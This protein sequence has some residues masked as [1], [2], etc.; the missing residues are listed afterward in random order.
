MATS[1]ASHT[2]TPEVALEGRSDDLA[3]LLV[4][5]SVEET[6]AG[7]SR[8][9]VRVDN[10]TNHSDGPGFLW[11]DR[12]LVDFGKALDVTMGPPDERALVFS[13]RI[14]GI[15]ADYDVTGPTLVL[16]AEDGLKDLRLTRRTRV[17]EDSTDQ[18]AIEAIAGDH[19]LTPEVE[20]DGASHAA[21][22]QLNQS[23]LA[24][25][26]DRA[27]PYG[28]DVWL[29][30]RTLHVGQRRDEAIVLRYGR[31]LLSV[32]LLADL[33]GQASEQRVTGW[34]P[35]TKQAVSESAGQSSLGAELGRD[36]G[37]GD[38]VA[39]AFGGKPR[40]AVA[41]L[42]RS[43]T[44][45]E[46]QA[47]ADGL[48]RERAR[49]FVTGSGIVDGIAALRAGRSVDVV[50]LGPVLDGTYRLSRVLHRYDRA[51]GYRTEVD[52]ERVGLGR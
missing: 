24:F 22:S 9:E 41:T 33:A 25:V 21:I 27:L 1:L 3:A 6:T 5:A 35:E 26:R 52:L 38:L 31:E 10:W 36:V 28:A 30:G 49:R 13:G 4:S 8:C 39:A 14:T 47:L 48:Y 37:G 11:R 32:R 16:L 29:D 23:D 42:H 51:A 43:V 18:A 34:D 12:D 40:P 50:D 7:M 15:E 20:L 2:P 44:S 45:K 19:G 46:A 17:F